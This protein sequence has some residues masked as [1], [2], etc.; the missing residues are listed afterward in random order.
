VRILAVSDEVDDRLQATELRRMAPDLIV[1]CGDVPFE[2]LG[3][4]ADASGA[5]VVFVPGNHDPDLS[6]YRPSRH[7]LVVRSGFV[8]AAPWPAGTIN[9]DGRVTEIAGIVVAGLGGSRRYRP[10]PNQ[11]SERRQARRG[12]HLVAR[13]R[14]RALRQRRAIDVLLTHA[15]PRRSGDERAGDRRPGDA[16]SVDDLLREGEDLAHQGFASY[17]GLVRALRP[18]LLLHG[19][20]APAVA[21]PDRWL[22]GT[23]VVNVFDHRLLD[24]PLTPDR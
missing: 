1:S 8:S 20:T 13:A 11:Y 12:R 5:A 18:R 17:V 19:H 24:L 6:G 14:W 15:G 23:Q 9:T 21:P 10:G 2:R 3:E 22:G 4:L 16:V 7:G